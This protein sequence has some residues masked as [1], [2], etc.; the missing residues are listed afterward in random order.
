MSSNGN[1]PFSGT[2]TRNILQHVLSP[3]MVSDGVEGSQVKL[4]LVNIDNV[5]VTGT[6]YRPTEPGG[7]MVWNS[8]LDIQDTNVGNMTTNSRVMAWVES[9]D[10]ADQG[11]CLVVATTPQNGYFSVRLSS[12]PT[13]PNSFVVAWQVF[14]L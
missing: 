4:D 6:V 2:N 9:T 1:D 14:K 7:K 5:Y 11:N 13:V 10:L 3:K 8:I 12:I